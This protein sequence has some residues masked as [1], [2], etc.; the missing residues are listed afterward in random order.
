MFAL[1]SLKLKIA[2]SFGACLVA[3][4]VILSA[5]TGIQ[6]W[7][8]A[9]S[10]GIE[11]ARSAAEH[12]AAAVRTR[13]GE[14]V[15][16]SINLG[17]VLESSQLGGLARNRD[18][19]NTV[20]R[21][22]LEEHTDFLGVWC[23]WEPDAF[24]G[25]DAQFRDTLG[26]DATGRF[27]PY[28][29][30]WGGIHV[31]PCTDYD[32]PG[33]NYYSLTKLYRK[34]II[35][36]PQTYLVRGTQI[37]MVSICVPIIVYGKFMGAAGADLSIGFIQNMIDDASLLN[38]RGAISIITDNGI[39]AGVTRRPDLFGQPANILLPDFYTSTFDRIRL[40]ESWVVPNGQ[41]G[42][43][44]VYL[45]IE[46]GKIRA[47]WYV[48]VLLPRDVIHH[49]ARMRGWTLGGIS[50]LLLSAGLAVMWLVASRIVRPITL[51]KDMALAIA[52]GDYSRRIDVHQKDEIGILAQSFNFMTTRLQEALQV[53]ELRIA[54]L[55]RAEKSLRESEQSL[56]TIFNSVHDAIIIH[57][58]DGIVVDV[59]TRMLET[60]RLSREEALAASF[61][62]DLS[63]PDAPVET[64]A[65]HWERVLDGQDVMLEW[66]NRRPSDGST[67][68]GEIHLRP[69]RIED[70]DLILASVRDVTDRKRAEE[71]L[72]QTR[73]Y[74]DNIV[75]SMPSL[76][77]GVDTTGSVTHWNS[78]A[79]RLTG[80][81]KS[82]ALGR[83]LA[84]CWPAFAPF[85]TS[86]TGAM[87]AREP[88][89][90]EKVQLPGFGGEDIHADVL[91]YPLIVNDVMGAVIRVDDVSSRVR[92]EE[93]MIQTEKMMSVGGLAAGMA[94]EI[95]NPLGAILQGV[96]NI[97]R[98]LSADLPA[99]VAAAHEC[100]CEIDAMRQFMEKRKILRFLDGIRESGER[101]ARIVRNMLNFS[102]M[103]ESRAT[104]EDLGQLIDRTVELAENDYDL[105]KRYDFRDTLIVREYDPELPP[106]PCIASEIEQVLFN[107]IKNA[108]QA[109][110]EI[111]G[112]REDQP[113]ITLRTMREHGM[114][115][116]EVEDNGP[117]IEEK[118]RKRVF[119]PFFTTKTVGV[120]TG[121]GLSVSYFIITNNHGGRFDVTS[122]PGRGTTFIIWLPLE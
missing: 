100:G 109:M 79:E 72:R 59:N 112:Q 1:H 15:T 58:P 23:I 24:D 31:E 64:L 78:H 61:T 25:R 91:I 32:T 80:V 14:V 85:M 67:F 5:Y 116:I 103:S 41:D 62:Q 12:A 105:K 4:A 21:N 49:E 3:T 75:N 114:A 13:L 65:E 7:R 51:A 108:A 69:I 33:G 34:P 56:L 43:F 107:L 77:V 120:G 97:Q 66:T 84:E 2:L 11:Q 30:R 82:E 118:T 50:L 48:C 28:W 106:V 37:S 27:L 98:R 35:L 121:L 117:G 6:F 18:N 55:S 94:H 40:G 29:N 76:I 17:V 102:R 57:T 47:P 119:E 52:E 113:R 86:V 63:A 90:E 70:R 44:E 9:S 38:A 81:S 26:H 46:F 68:I 96:Q 95:N 87:L 16:T 92:L 101:A 122:E 8:D 111:R 110:S 83:P 115:R 22:I 45:P 36:D 71:E 39:L 99:N 104:G 20:L 42:N 10:I 19:A 74:L 60:F 54:Q 88:V 93:M 73:G 53:L 89:L